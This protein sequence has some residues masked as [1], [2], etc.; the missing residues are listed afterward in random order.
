MSAVEMTPTQEYS[1]VDV[2]GLVEFFVK[3]GVEHDASNSG[4]YTEVEASYA[5]T[6]KRVL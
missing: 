6:W 5:E 2:K 4:T 3:K 1:S